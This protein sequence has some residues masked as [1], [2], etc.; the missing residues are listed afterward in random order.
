MEPANPRLVTTNTD[1]IKPEPK[2]IDFHISSLTIKSIRSFITKQEEDPSR[3]RRILAL[4]ESDLLI[5]RREILTSYL[6]RYDLELEDVE[7]VT[8]KAIMAEW[9]KVAKLIRGEKEVFNSRVNKIKGFD[10]KTK[11]KILQWQAMEDCATNVDSKIVKMIKK[12][13]AEEL[14]KGV[15][16]VKAKEVVL[17]VFKAR[18]DEIGDMFVA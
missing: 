6:Y 10:E 13:I 17:R 2:R 11:A 12:G 1:M 3:K 16:V 14:I 8:E 18:I 4:I 15:S 7:R 9:G 5:R